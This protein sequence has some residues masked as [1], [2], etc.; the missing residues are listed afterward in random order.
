MKKINLKLNSFRVFLATVL[1]SA[2]LLALSQSQS[3]TLYEPKHC[4]GF[5]LFKENP[6]VRTWNVSII[7]RTFNTNGTTTDVIALSELVGNFNYY[8]IPNEYFTN[9]ENYIY[10]YAVQGLS[11]NGQNIIVQDPLPCTGDQPSFQ[12]NSYWICSGYDYAYQITQFVNETQSLGNYVVESPGFVYEYFSAEDWPCFGNYSN[13]WWNSFDVLHGLTTG[14]CSDMQEYF[15]YPAAITIHPT[16]NDDVSYFDKFGALITS[17]TIY[18]VQKKM[19]YWPSG[20]I[21]ANNMTDVANL[22]AADLPGIVDFMNNQSNIDDLIA[23][24][25]CGELTCNFGGGYFDAS[26]PNNSTSGLIDCYL[27]N[28]NWN[29][30]PFDDMDY[31]GDESIDI[32]DDAYFISHNCELPSAPNPLL[33][34]ITYNKIDGSMSGPGERPAAHWT[35]PN[36]YDNNGNWILNGFTLEPGLYWIGIRYEGE[37]FV[38]Y[39]REIKETMVNT[40]LQSN[41][42]TATVF[43]V[44]IKGNTFSIHLQATANV[45][46][47]YELIDGQGQ[48]L[49]T[50]RFKLKQGYD[51]NV[52]IDPQVSLPDGLLVHRFVFADGSA[53]TITTIKN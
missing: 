44:P 53:K 40:S 52:A 5:L 42:L 49:Y 45:E 19:V 51:A 38:H 46:F 4:Q 43:E 2:Q 41:Q 17:S 9:G 37:P 23:D 10:L 16:E 29:N 18:G 47:G 39:F 35:K 27:E 31:N 25:I 36:I 24:S 11:N 15:D 34:E 32:W 33:A 8:R 1:C 6:Q 48:T 12:L 22:S 28:N 3:I 14:W 7:Q 21:Q 30:D 50:S 13:Q 26:E 20:S